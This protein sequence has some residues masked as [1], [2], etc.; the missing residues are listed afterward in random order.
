MKVDREESSFPVFGRALLV[1]LYPD[2]NPEGNGPMQASAAFKRT[3]R[4]RS[5][6]YAS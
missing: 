2:A 3:R 4:R 5:Q 1:G 6:V